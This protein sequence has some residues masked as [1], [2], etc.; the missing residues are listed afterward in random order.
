MT[1]NVRETDS[2]E[3]QSTPLEIPDPTKGADGQG[4]TE[5][6]VDEHAAM[7]QTVA[8]QYADA[9]GK[10][11]EPPSES[12]AGEKPN[13]D[14]VE[15]DKSKIS[16]YAMNPDHPQGRRKF[17]VINSATGLG[18]SDADRM[19]A[20]IREGVKR[21]QPMAGRNDQNGQRWSVDVPVTGPAGTMTVRTAWIVEPG[22]TTPRLAT[23]SFPP[24]G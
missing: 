13:F 10:R 11:Y 22:S 19:E 20:Q 1:E 9:L 23:I 2:A 21:G 14:N 5:Q 16:E 15:I 12:D 3:S 6:Q 8:R 4:G 24:N 17:R 18:Q 7:R